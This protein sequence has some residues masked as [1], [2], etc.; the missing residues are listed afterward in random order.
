MYLMVRA[1]YEYGFTPTFKSGAASYYD[2]GLSN[3][4]IYDKDNKNV[5][6][7]PM[8]SGLEISRQ[9]WWFSGGLKFKL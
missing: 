4:V 5:L 6:V 2:K 9:G 1:G 8:I 7:H 3:P